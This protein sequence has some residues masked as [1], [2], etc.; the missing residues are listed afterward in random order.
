MIIPFFTSNS[1]LVNMNNCLAEQVADLQNEVSRLIT[2][3]EQSVK[4]SED[5][6][7]VVRIQAAVIKGQDAV[8][9]TLTK[10]LRRATSILQE[11]QTCS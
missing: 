11:L 6:H 9:D 7:E 5:M 10:D 8:I 4:N 1:R 3:L 2:S